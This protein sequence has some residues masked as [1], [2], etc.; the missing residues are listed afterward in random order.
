MHRRL[1]VTNS[2]NN[3]DNIKKEM[4]LIEKELKKSTYS[5][6]LDIDENN[7]NSFIH[8]LCSLKEYLNVNFN[9][10]VQISDDDEYIIPNITDETF[11]NITKNNVTQDNSIDGAVFLDA[12][13]ELVTGDS[14]SEVSTI[15]LYQ[16]KSGK[17]G[18]VETD[19]K[20][21]F[22]SLEDL[23]SD[24]KEKNNK[25]TRNK[26]IDKINLIKNS[27]NS[28]NVLP[29]YLSLNKKIDPTPQA[30]YTLGEFIHS[31]NTNEVFD[32]T[33]N[34]VIFDQR[35]IYESTSKQT[36]SSTLNV[37]NIQQYSYPN[38][39]ISAYISFPYVLDYA[40]FLNSKNS[41]DLSKFQLDD[42]LFK[43][44]IRGNMGITS[45]NK[46]IYNT[47]L[48]GPKNFTGDAWWLSNGITIIAKDIIINFNSIVL[49]EPSIVN[50]QQTSRQLANVIT[51]DLPTF[52]ENNPTFSPWK[53]MVKLF[54]GDY[55]DPKI[56]EVISSIIDGLNSQSAINKNSVE[57]IYD[58]TEDLQS[59]LKSKHYS[60]ELRKGEFT[61]SERYKKAGQVHSI[62]NI[63]ELIQ[64]ALSAIFIKDDNNVAISIGQ[65]RSSKTTVV[66]KYHKK[67]F[68]NESIS[69][70][71]WERLVQC[72]LEYKNN[73]D[74]SDEEA[75]QGLKYLSFA[76]FRLIFIKY[77][78][79]NDT[80]TLINNNIIA[81]FDKS[82]IEKV[83]TDLSNEMKQYPDT[84]WDQE[85]KKASFEQILE[86]IYE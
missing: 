58:E 50:G 37:T 81:L 84:N 60:L 16:S 41:T 20:A 42:G 54:I 23:F 76:I 82:N 12:D 13:H 67:L 45:V 55:D 31:L 14:P 51:K 72:I 39:E 57:L 74:F 26:T 4:S 80:N 86:K 11:K 56:S 28:I 62:I 33:L 85:S 29:V 1:Q 66:K 73:I 59:Y 64:Y 15:V 24:N 65:I 9:I 43:K 79:D 47:F 32:I 48:Y 34:D 18:K 17:S 7:K 22:N 3:T 78:I 19:L 25:I 27:N 2:T 63:E 38:G 77:R 30:K 35:S 44:N 52:K 70:V 68:K 10:D 69:H 49:K 61:K 6:V 8:I 75:A 36:E 21:F 5:S 83:K 71:D 40:N 46:E 53:L